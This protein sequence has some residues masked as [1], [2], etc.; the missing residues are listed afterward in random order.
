LQKV[1]DR[2]TGPITEKKSIGTL[3]FGGM[4]QGGRIRFSPLGGLGLIS[5]TFGVAVVMLRN[6]TERR[7]E[8]AL[9]RAVG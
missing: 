3:T 2:K 7:G 6:I 5:G 9:F 8:L 1:F 4:V